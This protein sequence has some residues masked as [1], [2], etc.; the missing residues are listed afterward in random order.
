MVLNDQQER[1]YIQFAT[2]E[3]PDPTYKQVES[4][5]LQ[6]DLILRQRPTCE[7]TIVGHQKLCD[8]N[9]IELRLLGQEIEGNFFKPHD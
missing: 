6:A 4:K 9:M 5:G 8:E 2:K 3:G 7:W 1:I